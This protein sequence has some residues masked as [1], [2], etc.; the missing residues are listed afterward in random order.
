MVF[1]VVLEVVLALPAKSDELGVVS[2]SILQ[3]RA[4]FLNILAD[5]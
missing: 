1:Y 2:F 4:H 5:L 3:W